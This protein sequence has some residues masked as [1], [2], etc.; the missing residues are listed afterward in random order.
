MLD[1]FDSSVV[2]ILL[3]EQ[4]DGFVEC[5]LS[6]V[7]GDSRHGVQLIDVAVQSE[8]TIFTTLQAFEGFYDFE[9]HIE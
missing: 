8:S 5:G 3:P 7:T 1:P 4:N 6:V 2:V 9:L